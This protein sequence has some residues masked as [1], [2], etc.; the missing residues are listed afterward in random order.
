MLSRDK[1]AYVLR[2]SDIHGQVLQELTS[3]KN[4][5]DDYDANDLLHKCLDQIDSKEIN[6][7]MNN[8]TVVVLG[9]SSS[10]HGKPKHIVKYL[11]FNVVFKDID[12]DSFLRVFYNDTILQEVPATNY[13]QQ[14]Q[15]DIKYQNALTFK[16]FSKSQQ[17]HVCFFFVQGSA[18]P[19][20][21]ENI[22]SS[23]YLFIYDNPDVRY[24][25]YKVKYPWWV[26]GGQLYGKKLFHNQSIKFSADFTHVGLAQRENY[27][28]WKDD[29][30]Q[31]R[32]LNCNQ[33]SKYRKGIMC[34]IMTRKPKEKTN[35]KHRVWQDIF[36]SI[37]IEH[38][39]NCV[40]LKKNSTVKKFDLFRLI[41]IQNI[42]NYRD[43]CDAILD[44]ARFHCS[45]FF[46]F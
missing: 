46:Y 7:I 19:L 29:H 22:F 12:H 26:F 8:E 17:N 23:K 13:H 21:Q 9:S 16:F 44:H 18:K 27:T 33:I 5:V 2:V 25:D 6:K 28:T 42:S 40:I 14:V 38:Q 35:L 41:K 1:H 10:R 4:Y 43:Y 11:T 36:D 45:Y 31:F 20:Y 34:T 15:V 32:A 30:L 39:S 37:D 3:T 24:W